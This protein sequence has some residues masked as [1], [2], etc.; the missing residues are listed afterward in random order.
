LGTD[1][2][3][4]YSNNINVGTAT[5]TI[6]GIGNYTG[7]QDV[8]FLI[9]DVGPLALSAVAGHT[10]MAATLEADQLL[11]TA[12]AEPELAFRGAGQ[13]SAVTIAAMPMVQIA[14][15][16]DVASPFRTEKSPRT[17]LAS[18]TGY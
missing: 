13:T 9:T 16:E 7:T 18:L 12:V 11:A 3:V 8:T 2:T 14:P 10:S 5:A 4:A 17:L 6:T 1:Y 15:Q